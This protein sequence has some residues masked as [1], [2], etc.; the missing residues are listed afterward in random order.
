MRLAIRQL[1]DNALKYS[2]PDTPIAAR[3]TGGDGAVMIDVVDQGEGIP[4][5]DQERIFDRFYRGPSTSQIPG[6]GLGLSIAGTIVR[7][8]GGTLNVTSRPGETIF[9]IALPASE[10]GRS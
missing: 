10:G 9:R 2:P 8:H 1:V 6:S 4:P 7:A 3:I 5:K